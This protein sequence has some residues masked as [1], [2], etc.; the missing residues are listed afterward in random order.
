MLI[1][2][3]YTIFVTCKVFLLHIRFN[4]ISYQ[5]KSCWSYDWKT[6]TS[7]IHRTCLCIIKSVTSK[8]NISRWRV[9]QRIVKYIFTHFLLFGKYV[10]IC[11]KIYVYECVWVQHASHVIISNNIGPSRLQFVMHC[12]CTLTHRHHIL[13]LYHAA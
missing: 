9:K 1:Q 6:I 8:I 5:Y 3:S 2:S 7:E 10:T 11:M 4:L 12:D 13:S